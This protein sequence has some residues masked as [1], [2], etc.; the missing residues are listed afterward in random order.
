V[1]MA[2]D[3]YYSGDNPIKGSGISTE[4]ATAAVVIGAL[5]ALWM[6]RRGFR[7]VSVG[8]VSVGVR[9]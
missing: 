3:Q 6:L 8:G 7:G 5:V 1:T 9:G 2:P 4:H